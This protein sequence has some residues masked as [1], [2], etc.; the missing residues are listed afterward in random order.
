V[1]KTFDSIEK[2]RNSVIQHGMRSDRVYLMKL[3]LS[4][5]SSILNDIDNLAVKCGYSK[6][7]VKVSA[8]V[9]S[10]FENHGYEKEA[11]IPFF[12]DGEI[13]G[14]FLSKYYK[15]ER[16]EN[17]YSQ[18]IKDIIFL[19]Q[20]KAHDRIQENHKFKW[21]NIYLAKESDVGAMSKVYRE[22]F[23]SY[24][25]PIHDPEYLRETM[26][27][28]ID[29]FIVRHGQNIIALSSAEMD[30][31]SKNVEMTD[32]A[33]L[34]QYRKQGIAQKL[35][36]EMERNIKEKDFRMSYTIARAMSPGIN[37]TFARCGYTYAGTLI[38]NTN[39]SGSIESMNVWYKKL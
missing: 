16:K 4:D 37:I 30:Q 21:Y 5:M 32:F 11:V 29:Y 2:M 25:F 9:V 24:P 23:P 7:F 35:L 8:I 33:T 28:H 18:K 10:E 15:K 34:P 20:K 22:V 14:V 13:D 38:N 6:A 39:I 19:A 3:D 26:K 31:Q 12:F 36:H 1:S 27:R 17:I